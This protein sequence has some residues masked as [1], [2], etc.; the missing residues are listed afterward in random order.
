MDFEFRDTPKLA[1][2]RKEVRAWLD[3]HIPMDFEISDNRHD[4]LPGSTK[5][6]FIREARRKLG[7]KGWL[8]PTWPKEYGGGGLSEEEAWVIGEELAKR[9]WSRFGGP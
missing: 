1:E 5:Y 6:E 7:A 4:V 9:P 2:F 3:L 8:A